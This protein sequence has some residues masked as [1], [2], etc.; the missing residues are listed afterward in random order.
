MN[1]C[2]DYWGCIIH[3]TRVPPNWVR[4]FP[5]RAC[6]GPPASSRNVL[7]SGGRRDSFRENRDLFMDSI[8][9]DKPHNEA[10]RCAKAAMV[11]A[12][13][14]RMAIDAGK[15]L[16]WDEA[17]ASRTRATRPAP[18]EQ[19]QGLDSPAPV[20][21]DASSGCSMPVPGQAGVV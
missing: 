17:L 19:I 1:Q 15:R 4:V 6:S 12:V 10:E 8:R 13:M 7:G 5:S 18:S 9:N 14:G 2:Y 11:G 21:P 16:T 3:G 20:Q